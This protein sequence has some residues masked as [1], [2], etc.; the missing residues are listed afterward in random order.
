MA[1]AAAAYAVGEDVGRPYEVLVMGI[2]TGVMI[3]MA[4]IA[5]SGRLLSIISSVLFG[6]L[7]GILMVALSV[8]VIELAFGE[9]TQPLKR[10][11]TP[12]MAIL[13]VYI[14]VS[15]LYQTRE[16]FRI[17]IPYVEFRPEKKGARPVLLDTSVVVD[18][19]IAELLST[20]VIDG[21]ILVPHAILRELHGIADSEDKLKRERGRLGLRQLGAIRDDPRLEVRIE[22]FEVDD[23]QPVDEQLVRIAGKLN[24]RIMTNDFNLN[25]LAALEGVEIINLNELSNALKPVAL[26]DEQIS[27]KLVKRG[28][29]PGQA[30]G[31][32]QDG[33]MVVVEGAVHAIGEEVDV[34]VTNAITRDTGRMIFGRLATRSRS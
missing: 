30:V 22:G 11:L 12:A 1:W 8:L 21:P 18:G 5:L 23:G 28:E 19:R 17:I 32:L 10:N 24:A 34:L 6:T 25:R 13:F 3:V 26:P 33:T 31:Y 27:I 15:F 2:L 9:L 20:G 14:S 4:E 7:L 16:R 29:Q